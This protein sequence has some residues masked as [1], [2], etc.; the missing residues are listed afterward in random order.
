[1]NLGKSRSFHFIMIILFAILGNMIGDVVG[2]NFSSIKFL[3]TSYSFGNTQ[4]LTLDLGILNVTMGLK[5]NFNILSLV[6]IIIALIL[7]KKS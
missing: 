7:I 1:M 6:F 4:P 5:L 3:A 2:K